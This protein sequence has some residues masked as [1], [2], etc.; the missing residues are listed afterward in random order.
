MRTCVWKKASERVRE[1]G[2]CL[3]VTAVWQ[4]KET[5][6]RCLCASLSLYFLLIVIFCSVWAAVVFPTFGFS[7]LTSCVPS[8]A[9]FI[10][11]FLCTIERLGCGRVKRSESYS[12][13][14]GIG[15]WFEQEMDDSLGGM[16]KLT[17]SNYSVWKLKIGTC[18]WSKIYGYR[19]SLGTRDRTIS[20]PRH[21]S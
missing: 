5:R 19:F 21:G 16:F 8:L 17:G 3:I 10:F 12:Y 18:S 6:G 2:R 4:R 11:Y 13:Q 9:Y 15:A 20:M 1:R 14:S 7:T